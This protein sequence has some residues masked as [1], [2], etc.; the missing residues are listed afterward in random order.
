MARSRGGAGE[1]PVEHAR[2]CPAER[3]HGDVSTRPLVLGL[4][5]KELI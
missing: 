5:E 1:G 2:Q 3:A 4:G